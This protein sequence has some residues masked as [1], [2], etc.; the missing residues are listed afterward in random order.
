MTPL[1]LLL[2]H[3]TG[4]YYFEVLL[5]LRDT[6]TLA[7]YYFRYFLRYRTPLRPVYSADP[8]TFTATHQNTNNPSTTTSLHLPTPFALHT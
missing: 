6:T 3:T 5:S 2:R 1:P 8:A 4:S 7:V